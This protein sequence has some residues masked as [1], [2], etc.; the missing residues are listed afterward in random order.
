MRDIWWITYWRLLFSSIRLNKLLDFRDTTFYVWEV[1][2]LFSFGKVFYWCWGYCPPRI[3]N[4]KSFWC[5][6][7]LCQNYSRCIFSFV[8][9]LTTDPNVRNRRRQNIGNLRMQNVTGNETLAAPM[10]EEKSISLYPHVH[11]VNNPI[12]ISSNITESQGIDP[13][14]FHSSGNAPNTSNNGNASLSPR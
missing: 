2:C 3:W 12:P 4:S 5:H 10:Y 13:N 6:F 14:V 1:F 11:I 7:W 9:S 8:C